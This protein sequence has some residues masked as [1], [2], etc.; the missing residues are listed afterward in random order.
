MDPNSVVLRPERIE[1]LSKEIGGVLSQDLALIR[2]INKRTRLVSLNARIEAARAGSAGLAFAVVAGEVMELAKDMD[3]SFRNLETTT[4]PL[5]GELERLG[6]GLARNVRGQRLSDLAATHLDLV[7]RNLYE[8]SCD[9]RWWATEGALVKALESADPGDLGHAS[10]RMGKILDSYTVYFDLVLCDLGG[11]V[12]AN[13]RP[14][15]FQVAGLDVSSQEWFRGAIA[16]VSGAEFGFEG[17]HASALAGGQRVLVYS[18]AVRRGG[19]ENGSP[20]GVLGVV[21]RWDAL[22]QTI[23]DQAAVPAQDAARTR[24]LI[25]E[26][27]GRVIAA[28]GG[29]REGERLPLEEWLS[30]DSSARFYFES[31]SGGRRALVAVARSQGYETYSTGWI[32]A[33]VQHLDG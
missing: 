29:V 16:T 18:T 4:A 22:G 8:R 33:L 31:T 17:V 6:G 28:T 26:R 21:F 1:E 12:V 10:V 24:V 2:S 5:L 19:D 9:V 15:Q 3:S 30:R 20:I 13:G 25:A 23:V 7:D 32:G 27:C 11:R 14:E